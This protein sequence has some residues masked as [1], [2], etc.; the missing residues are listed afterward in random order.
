MIESRASRQST[1]VNPAI[2]NQQSSIEQSA[3]EQ[4]AIQSAIRNRRS[5]IDAC[6][7]A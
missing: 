2:D 6:P 1:I 3:I 4:S 5:A 7:N